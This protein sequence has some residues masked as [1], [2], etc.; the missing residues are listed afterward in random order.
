[1]QGK[2]E[3]LFSLFLIDW[4]TLKL[5]GTVSRTFILAL[6]GNGGSVSVPVA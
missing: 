5:G 4:Y 3:V 2:E 6:D 1:M